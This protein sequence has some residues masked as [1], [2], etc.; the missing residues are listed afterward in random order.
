MHS[1]LT[2]LALLA[3]IGSAVLSY[4][5][6]ESLTAA[7]ADNEAQVKSLARL[8][9]DLEDAKGTLADLTSQVESTTQEGETLADEAAKLD[10]EKLK[11]EEEIDLLSGE[12]DTAKGELEALK[13]QLSEVGNLE[14]AVARLD[15]LRTKNASLSNRLSSLEGQVGSAQRSAENLQSQIDKL[16]K[17]IEDRREGRLPENFSASITQVYPQ[18]GF[19]IVGAGNQQKA[20]E[21]AR[22]AV[23]RG[24]VEIGQIEITDLLQNRAVADVVKGTVAPGVQLR[25]GDRVYPLP[26]EQASN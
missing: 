2:T 18:W 1:L 3:L 4:M 17:E 6:K 22:L 16:S 12:L 8:E 14:E 13:L 24:G 23:R 25:A 5:N 11:K 7:R 10:A 15:S 9:T 19:V 26:K 21:G 20:A